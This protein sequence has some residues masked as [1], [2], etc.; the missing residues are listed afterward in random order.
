MR[1]ITG[2]NRVRVAALC[3]G[4]LLGISGA[5]FAQGKTYEGDIVAVDTKAMT[6][7]VKGTKAGENVE[8]AFHVD[9]GSQMFINGERRLLGEMVKGDHVVVTYSAMGASN[10]VVQVDRIHTRTRE[11]SF[12][13]DVIDV[14]NPAHTFTVKAIVDGKAQEMKFHVNPGAQL[15]IGGQRV[16]LEQIQKG[17]NVTVGYESISQVNHVRHVKRAGTT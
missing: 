16:L 3:T 12:T 8:M 4:V 1:T 10:T 14:D 15:L 9:P 7:T 6:Y 2:I 5:A 11:L 13:G 17:D